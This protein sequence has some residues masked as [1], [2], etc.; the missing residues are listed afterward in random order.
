[1]QLKGRGDSKVH[2]LSAYVIRRELFLSMGGPS[3]MSSI[4]GLKRLQIY[5]EE[6]AGISTEAE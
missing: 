4:S 6:L 3:L 1:M 5:V 2:C